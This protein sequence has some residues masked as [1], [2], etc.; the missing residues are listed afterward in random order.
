MLHL[1]IGEKRRVIGQNGMA[2][3]DFGYREICAWGKQ[4]GQII[5]PTGKRYILRER[6]RSSV[7]GERSFAAMPATKP[8][9]A[10]EN[11]V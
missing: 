2:R 11:A 8:G 7:A 4:L 3:D 6:D 10:R 1:L 5:Q 9:I